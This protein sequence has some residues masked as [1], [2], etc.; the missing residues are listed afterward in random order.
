MPDVNVGS[1]QTNTTPS[2]PQGTHWKSI[3]IGIIIGSVIIG[4]VTIAFYLYLN[5]PKEEISSKQTA[6]PKTSIPSSKTTKETEIEPSAQKSKTA[7]WK[8]HKGNLIS[9]EFK[10]PT[11][12]TAEEKDGVVLEINKVNTKIL[13]K[14]SSD[15][16]FLTFTKNF[17][18]GF[19]SSD[20]ELIDE[21]DITIDTYKTKQYFYHHENIEPAE[22]TMIIQMKINNEPFFIDA[23]LNK[24][25]TAKREIINN[26]LAT[27]DF[28]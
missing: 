8:I 9:I 16:L 19:G 7:G 15:K 28:K 21:Q 18:G 12:Y 2:K 14:D 27:V 1:P 20:L 26:I 3:I 24:N 11:N 25:D 10:I 6:T 23:S 13:V 17:L 5:K 22:Y 4:I